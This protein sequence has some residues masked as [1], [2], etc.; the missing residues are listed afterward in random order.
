[1]WQLYFCRCLYFYFAVKY[2]YQEKYTR[3]LS[4][5]DGSVRYD[6]ELL[7]ISP[8]LIFTLWA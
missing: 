6:H 2:S 1:M 7:I 5:P 8:E 3:A 4:C